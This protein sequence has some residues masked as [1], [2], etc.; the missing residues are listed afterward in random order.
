M[1]SFL[2]LLALIV[3]LAIIAR[4]APFEGAREFERFYAALRT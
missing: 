3:P 4:Y 1:R 2:H